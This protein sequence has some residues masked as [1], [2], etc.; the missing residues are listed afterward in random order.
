MCYYQGMFVLM[1]KLRIEG[2]TTKVTEI[3]KNL[4][5]FYDHVLYVIYG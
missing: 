4:L 1:I 2:S 3:Y 5:K